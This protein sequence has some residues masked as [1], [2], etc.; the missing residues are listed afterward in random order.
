MGDILSHPVSELA[1]RPP[2]T[3]DEGATLR[4]TA[5]RLSV[6]SVGAAVVLRK[7]RPVGIVS[8]R[9]IVDALANGANP[10]AYTAGEAMTPQILTAGPYDRVLT[11]AIDMVDREIRH[12]PLFDD[13]GR[14]VG[15]VS[16]RE[17]VR[18]LLVDALESGA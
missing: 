11:A 15:V 9:D 6:E 8:E 16:M 2:V 5:H 13:A 18:P 3:I 10:D 7:D 14:C 17:L 12:L 4:G 1:T